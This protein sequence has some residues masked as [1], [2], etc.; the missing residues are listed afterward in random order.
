M[1]EL[2]ETEAVVI[3]AGLVGLA[4]AR[5]LALAGIDTVI[6]EAEAS[7]GQGIS[8]RNSESESVM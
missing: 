3:G 1:S 8:S 7:I 4:C 2:L 5:R 6:L